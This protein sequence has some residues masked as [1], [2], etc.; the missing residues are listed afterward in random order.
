[1]TV[2][3][4]LPGTSDTSLSE[5]DL[6]RGYSTV[7]IGPSGVGGLHVNDKINASNSPHARTI[8]D[9]IADAGLNV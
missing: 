2:R 3:E 7:P 9:W 6:A 1:M 8:P 4:R 5:T